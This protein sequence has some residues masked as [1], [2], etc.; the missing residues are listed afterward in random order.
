MKAVP[1]K[2]SRRIPRVDAIDLLEDKYFTIYI[3]LPFNIKSLKDYLETLYTSKKVDK[4][5]KHFDSCLIPHWISDSKGNIYPYKELLLRI[6]ELIPL[7]LELEDRKI[8]NFTQRIELELE[9]LDIP[10]KK[11]YKVT[12]LFNI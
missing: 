8:R 2:G 5:P 11:V 7:L 9:K 1:L 6:Y 4:T 12:P 10:F 3:T